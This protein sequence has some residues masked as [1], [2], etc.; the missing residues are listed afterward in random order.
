MNN[1]P[2]S[3][4]SATSFVPGASINDTPED[5]SSERR[6]GARPPPL[7][8][9]KRLWSETDRYALKDLTIPRRKASVRIR[10][11]TVYPEVLNGA[12]QLPMCNRVSTGHYRIIL[13][14][15]SP[16]SQ[17]IS[18]SLR[19]CSCAI[20]SGGG[21]RTTY[22]CLVASFR[23]GSFI[24]SIEAKRQCRVIRWHKRLPSTQSTSD[25]N[26]SWNG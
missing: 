26:L 4:L 5:C 12:G 11:T 20:V 25:R 18:T 17:K 1:S 10:F 24:Q 13:T 15:D 16:K 23:V 6:M 9:R 3:I 14:K 21:E 19:G 7:G 2:I 22:A 8:P